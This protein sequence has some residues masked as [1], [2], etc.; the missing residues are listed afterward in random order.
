MSVF[1]VAAIL[2]AVAAVSGYINHRILHLPP[3]SGTLLVALA[4][5]LVVVLLEQV[6][7]GMQLRP[8]VES[9]LGQIDFDR[10]LMH[11]LLCFLL[12]AGALHVDRPRVATRATRGS[13]ERRLEAKR[14]RSDAK[15]QRRRPIQDD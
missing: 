1:D 10:T 3:T 12:F 15:R 8:L 9:F 5:S 6:V 2:T 7:P 14:Q 4:A 13:Q 11:G